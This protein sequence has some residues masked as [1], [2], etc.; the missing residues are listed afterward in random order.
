MPFGGVDTAGN[1]EGQGVAGYGLQGAPDVH[2]HHSAFWG[3]GGGWW[4]HFGD[5]GVEEFEA[6]AAG[7]VPVD[8][9]DGGCV[10]FY[11]A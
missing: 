1:H 9:V 11:T 7:C 10:G 8:G 4:G 6:A 2:E 5:T 3:E